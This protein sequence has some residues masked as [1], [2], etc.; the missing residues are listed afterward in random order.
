MK[1]IRIVLS[2]EA[3]KAYEYLITQSQHSKIEKTILKSFRKKIEHLKNNP[4]YGSPIAKKLIPKEYRIKYNITNLFRLELPNFWRMLYTMTNN[5]GK[6]EIV[7]FMLDIVNHKKYN[8][9]F[10]Y[11]NG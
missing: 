10:G 3:K 7:I 8:R 5:G 6:I 2:D 1:S 4:H 9:I 11:N